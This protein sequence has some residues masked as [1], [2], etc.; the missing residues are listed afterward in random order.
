MPSLRRWCARRF[1]KS[2]ACRANSASTSRPRRR[3]KQH[4]SAILNRTWPRWPI[5]TG[6]RGR[7]QIPRRRF[8]TRA[9]LATPPICFSHTKKRAHIGK[10]RS[11]LLRLLGD[12]LVSN[13]AKAI[14]YLEA[15]ALLF[16]EMGDDQ[17]VCDMHL[18]LMAYLSGSNVGTMDVRRAMPHY[19]KAE[20]FLATQPESHRHAT[21]YISMAAAYSSTKRID[22]GL[23]TAKRAMEISERLDQPFLRDAYWSMAA[24]LASVFLV[25]S[26]SV[27]EGLRLADQARR[28]ADAINDTMVGSVV[29]LSGG[30]I[31]RRLRNPREAQGWFTRELAQP[32]SADAFRRLAPNP[33]TRTDNTPLRVHNPL[34][35]ACIDAGDLVEARAYLAEVDAADKPAELLFYEGEWEIAGKMLTADFEQS[36]RT[37]NRQEELGT[38]LDLVA[39]AHRFAAERARAVQVLQQALEISMEGGY[40]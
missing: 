25:H 38:A 6:P 30:S 36:R 40:I 1:M 9:V 7:P 18:R 33:Q 31:Y 35:T 23:P 4:I 13:G 24:I 8:T 37:G 11:K 19:K 5:T 34:V 26:G 10:R 27:T 16:E 20:A 32:R 29:A 21:F 2:C 28:R 39:L 22:D 14:E 15:A 12:E 17:A 3:S